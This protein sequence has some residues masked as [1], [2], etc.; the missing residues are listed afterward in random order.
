MRIVMTLVVRNEADV[1]DSNLRAHRALGVDAFAVLDNGSTDGTAELLAR[2]SDA[3]LAHVTTDPDADTDEVFLEWQ[4]RLALLAATELGA[5]WVI[6]NDG[7]EFWLPLDGDL[8]AAFAAVPAHWSGVVAPRLEFVPRPDGP[9]PYWERMTIRERGTRVLPKLA[10]RAG[11]DIRV[12]PGSHH[13]MSPSLGVQETAGKPSLR[14]L[15]EKPPQPPLIAPAPLFPVSILHLPLRSFEQYRSRL[16]I[17]LRIAETRGGEQLADRIHEVIGED[18]ARRRWD[19]LV[20]DDDA[21]RAGIE[22]GELVEDTRLRDLLRTQPE[23]GKPAALSGVD[24]SIV[25]PAGDTLRE[26]VTAA[27]L[28]G[29]AHNHAQALAERDASRSSLGRARGRLDDARAKLAKTRTRALQRQRKLTAA[30]R[31]ARKAEKRLRRIEASRWWRLRPRLPKRRPR[32][33][34]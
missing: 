18:D 7:D 16:D 34:A 30:R 4:T 25:A 8:K 28:A 14:G 31:R 2:W 6:N 11:S 22:R 19:E 29:L 5:D 33:P 21:A 20:C 12:G 27:A 32:P 26:E 24:M 9:E 23:G 10:H 13:V 15:R 3:G 1:L 17:G